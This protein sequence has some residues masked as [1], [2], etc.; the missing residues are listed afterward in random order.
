MG[1]YLD[2]RVGQAQ[3]PNNSGRNP[4][5]LLFLKPLLCFNKARSKDRLFKTFL[6]LKKDKVGHKLPIHKKDPLKIL[7]LIAG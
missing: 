5:M 3:G 4:Q 2:R 1:L 7:Y 6:D